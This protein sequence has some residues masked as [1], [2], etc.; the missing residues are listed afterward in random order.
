MPRAKPQPKPIIL[1]EEQQAV[2]NA[3]HGYWC[4][5]AGPGAGKS[6]TLIQRYARLIQEDVSP[7][8]I[9]S[10]SFTATAAKNLRDRVEQRVGKLTTTRTAGAVTFHSLALSFAQEE[11]DAFPFSLSEFPLATEPV[12]NKLASAAARRYDLDFRN[13]RTYVGL[14]RR[15]RVSPAQGVRDA[16]NSLN[17]KELKLALAYQVYDKSLRAEGLLD[18]DALI[19][20]MVE[21]LDKQPEIQS[22]HRYDFLQM[23]EAQDCS[24]IEWDLAKLI[25]GQSVLAVGDISQGVYGFRGS[26]PKLFANMSDIFPGTQTLYL[27]HN[28]RSSPQIVDFIRPLAASQTLAEKFHTSNASG[29]TPQIKAF[30][31]SSE[32]AAWVVVNQ[33][34]ESS[35]TAILSRTNRQLSPYE[36]LL[37]DAG[38]KYHLVGR[39]GFWSQPECRAVISYAECAIFPS[40]WAIQGAV[41]SPFWP[42]QYLPKTKLAA[43]LKELGGNY[44]PLLVHEKHSL[45]EE[46][47]IS[48]LDEF[49]QFVGNVRRYANL[50]AAEAVKQIIVSLKAIDHLV[51]ESAIDNDP[52]ENLNELQKIAARFGTLKEFLDYARRAANA[53]KGKKG[54]ALSTIHG[55]KGLQWSR[56]FVVGCQEGMMPHAKATDLDEERNIFFVGVSRSERE[57]IVSYA[58]VPSPFLKKFLEAK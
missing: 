29:P 47:N 18:F 21:I 11:R 16:E 17:P 27:S 52:I 51:E 42:S 33:I 10:L 2:V 25:A 20:Y 36:Q 9:L 53:A 40:N 22:Q 38:I 6:Q 45:V 23:D 19:F 1:N 35:Y 57:L 58:G 13:L 44:W 5:Q 49:V 54:V 26:D 15:Q 4:I 34:K 39:S 41:R 56:V 48:S 50:P 14:R 43:R 32:E 46:K 3:G 24:R 31:T 30:Q 28:Y 12:A 8:S 37:S 55:A 7:D